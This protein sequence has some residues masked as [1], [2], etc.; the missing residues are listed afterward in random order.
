MEPAPTHTHLGHRPRAAVV[1]AAGGDLRL[2]SSYP[3]VLRRVGGVRLLERTVKVLREAGL[4]RII[5]VVGQ[6]GDEIAAVV[7]AK[8]L[9]VD[10]IANDDWR[11]GT[12]TSVLIGVRAVDDPRC[13]VVMGDHMFEPDDVCH[14]LDA[15]GRNVLAVDRDLGRQV[16]GLGGIPPARTLTDGGRVVELAEQLIDFNAVDAGFMTV[17]REDVLATAERAPVTSWVALRQE[18]LAAGCDLT[19]SDVAGLWAPVDTPE[20]VRPLERVM[21]RRYGPKPTDGIIARLILRRISGP[22]TRQLLRIGMSPHVA[23]V[24]AFTVTLFAAGLIAVGDTWPMRA[25]G[26]GVVL[27]CA[28]DGVDGELARVSGRVT[29]RGALLDTLLD[30]YADLAVVLGLVLGA[31]GS[32]DAWVWG[33]AAGSGCLLVSYVHA[34]GRDLDVHLLLRREFRLLIF[35]LCAIAELPMWGLGFVAVAANADVVRG[36]VLLLRAS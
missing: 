15:A 2:R 18:M 34:I 5:V 3:A 12:G 16:G 35:A 27:G 26:V 14:L 8:H 4:E 30:R 25:G 24:L 33:F 32:R 1:V 6:R 29:R 13:L 17:Q 10:V 31:G 9:P 36:L 11:A 7:R 21:W 22:M 28:L 20:G 19:T 23:T